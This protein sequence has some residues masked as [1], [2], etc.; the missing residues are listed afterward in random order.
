MMSID[1]RMAPLMVGIDAARQHLDMADW[2][3]RTFCMGIRTPGIRNSGIKQALGAHRETNLQNHLRLPMKLSD[4]HIPVY[5]GSQDLYSLLEDITG[6]FDSH[7]SCL[8][9]QILLYLQTPNTLH[10]DEHCLSG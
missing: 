1:R 3:K 8:A 2:G 9:K 7:V 6:S 4:G 10:L 5:R